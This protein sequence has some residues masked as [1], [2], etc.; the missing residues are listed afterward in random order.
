MS[1][2]VRRLFEGFQPTSYQLFLDPDKETRTVRGNVTITG[3]RKG[4]PSQRLTFH[5]HGVKVI[6]AS[7]T[8]H[9][10]KGEQQITI[11]RIN[12]QQTLE[13]VRLHSDTLLHAG[14]Y[15]VVM[16]FEATISDGM[17]GIYSSDYRVG[18]QTY[19]LLSTQFESHY[20]RRAFPCID[21]P[22]A[23]ATFTLTLTGPKDEVVLS[24]MP[25]LNQSEKDGKMVTTFETTPKMSTYLLGFVIGELQS[26]ETKT[27]SGVNVR[28]WAT[29]AHRPEALDFALD[30]SKRSI[31]FFAD[32]Y[33][34]PYPLAKCDNVAIPDFSAGG[35]ENWGL[36][37]YRESVLIADPDTSAQS[38]REVIAEVVAHEASHQWFGDL[39]TMKWWDEI[40]LNESFANIMAYVA[41]DALFPEWH[42]WDSYVIDEGLQALRRDSIAGVQAVHTA[43]HHPDEISSLFDPSIVYAKGGRLLNTLI[44]YLGTEDFRKGLQTYFATHS[45][46]N[47]TA[48]DLWEALSAASGKNVVG[49]MEPWLERSGF[50][51]V[52]ATQKDRRVSVTQHHFLLDMSKAD[53]GRLWPVPLLADLP[54][55]PDLFTKA[56][57][58]FMLASSEPVR[59]NRGAIGHYIVHYTEP[60]HA[61]ALAKL[62]QHKQLA[63]SE[64]LML[65]NDSSMLSR[66]GLQ[67]YD[68]TLKLLAHYNDEDSEPVWGMMGV[69]LG[70]GRRFIDS[71]TS[72]EAPIKQAIRTLIQKQYERLGWE[73]KID[74]SSQDIKLRGTIIGLGVY[75]EHPDVTAKALT[76]F[77]AYKKDAQA[78]PAEIRDVVFGC[79]VRNHHEGAFE[80]LIN[81]IET[82]QN[83]DLKQDILTALTATQRED[84]TTIL[85]GRL[86]DSTKVRQQD[87]DHWLVSLLRNRY[88]RMLAWQWMQSEWPWLEATFS[89]DSSYDYLPRYAASAF[90]TRQLLEE[91]QTFFAPKTDQIALAHN[92]TLGVEE[93]ETRI[94]WLERDLPS[95]QAFYIS[96]NL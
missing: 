71:D 19:R 61:E 75:A 20:A 81:L 5:Q 34:T 33:H 56:K 6:S 94:A 44:R 8:K 55:V 2:N 80:Y 83:V 60:A 51:V 45:Y 73:Q 28:V 69:I 86:Q 79:A 32:Y 90:N 42:I 46:G 89:K 91:Y 84:E 50:P 21:E 76:L 11:S 15:T 87:V 9:D 57:K 59:F 17:N 43:V 67:S 62:A 88:S 35:M 93:L 16:E 68:A 29:K 82:T 18:E 30:V 70:E 39:V 24:N 36:L 48:K 49:F 7:V 22:E 95:V 4:R 27:N 41:M 53:T 65:L 12:H 1:K 23:K 3:L 10:K 77:E 66:A 72:L 47:T 52:A 85:L 92:I 58:T 40:W 38:T 63:V 37:T 26:R 64:R 14:Q 13:E 96:T 31:E 25:A 74:E 78:V 54:A